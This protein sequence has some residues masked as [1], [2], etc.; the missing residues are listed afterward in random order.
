MSKEQQDAFIL[1]DNTCLRIRIVQ[2]STAHTNA[3][4]R[5]RL[6]R[7]TSRAGH[8]KSMSF[9]DAGC[10]NVRN[11]SPR[12]EASYPTRTEP[13]ATPRLN[14]TPPLGYAE[15]PRHSRPYSRK[16]LLS[17][18]TM[19]QGQGPGTNAAPW[20]KIPVTTAT[21]KPYEV[22]WLKAEISNLGQAKLISA[23]TV[24][25]VGAF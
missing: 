20:N 3:K 8:V 6:Q 7:N 23:Q 21:S 10:R 17:D 16:T 13:S 15:S 12:N 25:N 14:S 5:D 9:H 1:T 2:C 19:I 18:L 24:L 22:S 11:R 4:Y